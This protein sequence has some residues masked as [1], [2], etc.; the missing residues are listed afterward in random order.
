VRRSKGFTLVEMMIVVA[1]VGVVAIVVVP[2]FM[3]STNLAEMRAA[4]RKLRSTV[5]RARTL[6]ATGKNENY[7]GWNP[8]DRTVEAGIQIDATGYRL[9]V[10]NDRNAGNE[11]V[12]EIVNF[13]PASGPHSAPNLSITQPAAGTQ[14]RFQK[15]GTL[16]GGANQFITIQDIS[17]MQMTV[18]IS[19][20]GGTEV[21]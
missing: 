21:Q 18:A 15:N 14:I 10:D 12:I 4:T 5:A 19:F 1:I 17:G 16:V 20:G 9:F 8:N 3:R 13:A 6:A 11:A 7:T 2:Q